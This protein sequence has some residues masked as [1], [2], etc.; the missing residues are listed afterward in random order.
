MKRAERRL[1]P[2][3]DTA[4]R[5][6]SNSDGKCCFGIRERYCFM[7]G[8]P[9]LDK[10]IDDFNK[11]MN[12]EYNRKRVIKLKKF[13]FEIQS[14]VVDEIEAETVEDACL[15][16]MEYLEEGNYDD[17]LREES[18]VSDGIEIQGECT[19]G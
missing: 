17:A 4:C 11:D 16:V 7:E 8:K 12:R 1:Y 18:S 19:N 3:E 10:V 5:F 6:R 13:K 2:C 9:E 15:K 14:L